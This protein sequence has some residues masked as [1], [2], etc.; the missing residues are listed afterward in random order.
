MTRHAQCAFLFNSETVTLAVSTFGVQVRFT[1]AASNDCVM[2]GNNSNT[3]CAHD[4]EWPASYDA[5]STNGETSSS[6]TDVQ[7]A[8]YNKGVGDYTVSS[9]QICVM[10]Y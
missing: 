6:L 9:Y 4:F 2:L 7:S 3:N 10:F 1:S 8:E 5:V